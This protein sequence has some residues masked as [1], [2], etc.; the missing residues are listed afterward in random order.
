[1][2]LGHGRADRRRGQ[3]PDGEWGRPGG[4][5]KWLF[6]PT[7]NKGAQIGGTAALVLTVQCPSTTTPTLSVKLFAAKTPA[8]VLGTGSVTTTNNC[9]AGNFLR[10]DIPL[11]IT[12]T[13]TIAKTDQLVLTVTTNVVVRLGYG[14]NAHNARL[15][16][17]VK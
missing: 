11:T 4:L 2:Q 12:G 7:A 10:V 16:L 9:N 3:V 1:M 14:S 5:A 17:A 6:Q 15:T 13:P 8:T